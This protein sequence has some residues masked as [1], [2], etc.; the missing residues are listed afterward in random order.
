MYCQLPKLV[1]MEPIM[2]VLPQA[3][4]TIA[5]IQWLQRWGF[6][7][8]SGAVI[9]ILFCCMASTA[10][11]CPGYP[12]VRVKLWRIYRVLGLYWCFYIGDKP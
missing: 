7:S 10:V 5:A 6:Q 3:W 11:A 8:R 4:M 2:V 9:V 1:G 12:E